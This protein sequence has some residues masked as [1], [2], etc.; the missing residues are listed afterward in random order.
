MWL[1]D[2]W[3]DFA[4]LDAGN[5]EKLERWG[6]ALLL[7]PDPQAIWSPAGDLA[8]TPGL[9]GHYHRSREG[10]GSWEV[11]RKLPERWQIGFDD[12][13]FHVGPMGFKHTGLFPEQAVNWRWVRQRI[14]A[15]GK[16][17]Q[18][19]N[20]FAYTGGATVA[21]MM[22]GAQVVHVDASK[23]MTAWAKENVALNGLAQRPVRFIV[24]DCLKFVRR[25]ARRGHL[26]QGIIMDPPSYGRGPDGEMWRMED[27]IFE[28]LQ[29]CLEVLAPSPAFFLINSYTTGL[30]PAVLRNLLSLTVAEKCGGQVA[31]DEVGLP[32]LARGLVLPCGASGRWQP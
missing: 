8:R 17:C 16:P 10:G 5:G 1:A 22:E 7:R 26:Y 18:V 29:A 32:I 13:R 23:G 6:E 3:R 9:A 24:E 19:L 15:Y 2:G 4:V 11:F 28:L 31:S 12:M 30:Q 25:E 14:R 27:K 21:C 20:L